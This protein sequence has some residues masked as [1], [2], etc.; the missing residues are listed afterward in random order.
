M[1]RGVGTPFLVPQIAPSISQE[2]RPGTYFV[3]DG[4]GKWELGERN[5]RAT[6]DWVRLHVLP[7]GNTEENSNE[8]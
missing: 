6:A 2:K 3:G 8:K 5:D 7:L 1:P 4:L